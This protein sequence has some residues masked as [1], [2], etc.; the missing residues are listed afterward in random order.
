MKRQ[1]KN[2]N[3]RPEI[4]GSVVNMDQMEYIVTEDHKTEF[5]D[6]I[7][8]KQGE[9]VIITEEASEKWPNW[10]L[11]TK[12][13]GSN[14]GWVPEQIIKYE[15]KYGTITEDYSAKELNIAKG[16]IVEGLKELN[17]WLWSK[18]IKTNEFGWIPL[19]KTKKLKLR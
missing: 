5:P 17:G 16:T 2:S 8:L 9:K 19:G 15:N 10:I 1:E 3:T 4:S 18:D 6:P 11:C 12:I 14:K 13:D 7:L